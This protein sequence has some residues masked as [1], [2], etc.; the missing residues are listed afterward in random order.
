MEFMSQ[1]K[2][3]LDK[4]I[5]EQI[6]RWQIDQKKRYK[7]PIRP[8]I[9]MSRLPGAGGDSIARRVA[10]DLQIDLFDTEIVSRIAE[11]SK[12]SKQV[13][14]SLDEQDRSIFNDWLK[15]LDKDH[16]WSD[17]YLQHL[18]RVVSAIGTHGHAFI[19]GRG[20]GFIL[21]E[22]VCLRLLVV[23]PL[24]TRIDNVVKA[25]GVSEEE[26]RK[27]LLKSE[28]ARKAFIR[29][30]FNKDMLDP[31]NYDLVLNTKNLS[32]DAASNIIKEAF[33]SREW[34]NYNVRK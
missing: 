24:Q 10:E 19:V 11:S 1:K 13:V 23:A 31:L 16:L 3:S 6:K 29:K 34:Y 7:K 4:I 5:E 22:E 25:F 20:A 2:H 27:R 33:N 17:E 30:Y 14:E 8:V 26:A 12:V 18:T 32:I 9:T 15:F 21:P 28:S